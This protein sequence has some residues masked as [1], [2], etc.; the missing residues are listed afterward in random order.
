MNLHGCT[1]DYSSI[2]ALQ[3]NVTFTLNIKFL[4]IYIHIKIYKCKNFA[5]CC[6][7]DLLAIQFKGKLEST[8][9]KPYKTTKRPQKHSKNWISRLTAWG[10]LTFDFF[11]TTLNVTDPLLLLGYNYNINSPI[12]LQFHKNLMCAKKC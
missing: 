9:K 5:S 2:A 7:N 1:A 8:K 12:H 11:L 3:I 6:L 10:N 4:Y